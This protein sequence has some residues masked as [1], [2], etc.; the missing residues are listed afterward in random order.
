MPWQEIVNTARTNLFK[1][2]Q[3]YVHSFDL[4]R[5]KDDKRFNKLYLLVC[6]A[7]NEL[8]SGFE[9]NA[10]TVNYINSPKN[11]IHEHVDDNVGLSLTFAVGNYEGGKLSFR[12]A[13]GFHPYDING[14]IIQYDGAKPHRV[15]PLVYDAGYR[16]ARYSFVIY[17]IDKTK[18][19]RK[20]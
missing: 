8:V 4:C 1:G 18:R 14:K 3:N 17:K 9:F 12:H 13:D 6:Q 5:Y 15:E 16:P 2:D 19:R 11:H 10:I 20:A 7:V